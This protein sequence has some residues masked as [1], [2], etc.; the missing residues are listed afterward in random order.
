MQLYSTNNKAQTATLKEAVIQGLAPDGGLFMPTEIP[1]LPEEFFQKTHS[2]QE[3]SFEVAKTLLQDSI[4]GDDLKTIID[5]AI[6]F[7]APLVNIHD[8]IN[9]LELFHGP[10]LA[11][12]DFGARFMA[13]LMQYFIEPG[14]KI[15]ILAATSGD[16]GSAVAQG[17]LNIPGI[18]V[19]LLYP[20]GKVSR[21]Q[22][23]QLTTIGQ[24]VTALEV[25]GTF[26]DCQAMVKEAFNNEELKNRI[27]LSSANSINIARLIPQTFY[28]FYAYSKIKNP[29]VFSVPSGN[30]GNLTAGLIAKKMGLPVKRFLAVSNSNDT[31]PLYVTTGKYK[32]KPSVTTISNAMDVGNPSNF[33]RILALYDNDITKIREDIWAKSYSDESTRRTIYEVSN[34]YDYILDPHGAVAYLGLTEYLKDDKETPG[35][36]LETAHP[37]KFMDVV[38][39][40][41]KVPIKT[42]ERLAEC[43]KKPKKSIKISNTFEDLKKFL[44]Q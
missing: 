36:F 3:I 21:I 8:N 1:K 33:A 16:T 37:A 17:F 10:T 34:N 15:T 41:A 25:E 27:K 40:M 2:F 5:E 32:A 29:L 24:N 35:I 28:Y 12:K 9:S 43:L 30:L 13:R 44:L 4:P 22:E 18:N 23:Q 38:E 14:E 7:D 11:F 31:F 39:P 20:S 42:P 26:D 6:N 19:V